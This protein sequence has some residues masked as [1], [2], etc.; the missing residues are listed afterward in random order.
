VTR[1]TMWLPV[2]IL[3]LPLLGLCQSEVQE[4]APMYSY[5]ANWEVPR[6]KFKAMEEQLTRNTS[7]M[8]KHLS[9]GDLV[10]YGTDFTIVHQDGES[11]HDVWW[12]STSWSGLM[13]ALESIKAA[14]T[15]AQVLSSGKHSDRV[16]V[17]RY[18][19]WRSGPFTNGYTRLAVYKLKPGA[20]EDAV[21]QMAKSFIVPMYEKLL[22][23]GAIH[24]YEIDQEA[25]HTGDPSTFTVIFVGNGPEGLDKGMAA[26]AAAT[27]AAPFVLS[28]FRNWG[29]PSAHRDGLYKTLATYK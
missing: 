4:K 10:G 18:Y 23:D 1:R 26:L 5:V 24:E 29:E 7:V 21:D 9:A 8:A 11:T 22:A 17:S 2:G 27:K 6:D 3:A 13:K 19:N 14:S 16:Y 20:P 28:S 15:D 25:V 12:S